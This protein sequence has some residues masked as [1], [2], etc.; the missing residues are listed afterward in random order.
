MNREKFGSTVARWLQRNHFSVDVSQ[1]PLSIYLLP[2]KVLLYYWYFHQKELPLHEA[3]LYR[4][5]EY[6]HA[7]AVAY[8]LLDRGLQDFSL[9]RY[10]VI[11]YLFFVVDILIL[12]LSW[13]RILF[14]ITSLDII[15][16]SVH[17]L[18]CSLWF[19]QKSRI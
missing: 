4:Q 15:F 6:T 5:P 19:T 17:S 1:S 11:L 2:L 9:L 8:P 12:F 14:Q 18:M 10:A 7:Y 3:S 13:M 16:N